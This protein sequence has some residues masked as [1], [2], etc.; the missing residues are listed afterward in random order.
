MSTR[1]SEIS[2]DQREQLIQ[3]NK[4]SGKFAIQL[5]ESTDTA[6]VAYLLSY[7]VRYIHNHEIEED[8]LFCIRLP[9]RTTGMDTFQKT[10]DFLRMLDYSG[11]TVLE[12]A[13][14]ALQQWQDIQ[15]GFM[16][17]CGL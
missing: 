5:D 13:L 9:E 2:Q 12:C 7:N 3:R 6:N 15:L 10:N 1:I 14:T 16:L 11:R 4:E 17:E 8:S